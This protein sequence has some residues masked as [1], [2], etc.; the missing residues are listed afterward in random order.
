MLYRIEPT[1]FIDPIFILDEDIA[2]AGC[3]ERTRHYTADF[4]PTA[5]DD[6]GL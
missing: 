5:S 3:C 4:D 6:D 2:N 1:F